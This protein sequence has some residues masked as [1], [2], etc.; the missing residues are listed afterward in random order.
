MKTD[1]LE[2]F[3]NENRDGFDDLTP[4]PA[5]WP[6]IQ[7]NTTKVKTFSIYKLMLRVAAVVVIF[8]SSYV[9]HDYRS[10][11]KQS[12]MLMEAADQSQL[13]EA[14]NFFEA[15]AYYASLIGNKEKEVFHLIKEYPELKNELKTEFKEVDRELSELQKDLKDGAMNEVIIEA[16]I[17]KY[18][19]KLNILEEVLLAISE[20]QNTQKT[21][22]HEI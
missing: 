15:K 8:V 6:Q 3:V 18:R 14:K 9:F 17:Q 16:M 2:K 10:E 21:V 11:N 12:A 13:E 22:E 1:E 7:K 20:D 19:L 4:D 5:I